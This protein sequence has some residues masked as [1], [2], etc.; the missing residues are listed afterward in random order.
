MAKIN[1]SSLLNLQRDKNVL[2]KEW[3]KTYRGYFG[4]KKNMQHFVNKAIPKLPKKKKLNILYA[5]SAGGII[6]EMM[7]KALKRKGIEAK[8]WIVD[9]SS[10][11]LKE[12]KNPKTKKVKADL[13]TLSLNEKFDAII[14]RSSLDYFSTESLQVKVLSNLRKHLAK[15]GIFFNQAASMPSIA[16]RNLANRI[17]KSNKKIGRRHFQCRQ[18]VGKIYREA[19]FKAIKEIGKGPALLLTEKDH[20]KRYEFNKKEI[21]KIQRTIERVDGKKR[22]NIR[23]TKKGYEMKFVFPIYYSVK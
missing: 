14:M 6:G 13:A 4:N 16:E 17:Y 1:Q 19:G 5:A 15:E 7:V 11:Q 9:I 3:T 22:P 8:L 20:I 18:D 10:K 12:N 21:E 2:G 23:T